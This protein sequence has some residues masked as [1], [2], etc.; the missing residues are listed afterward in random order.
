MDK[1]GVFVLKIVAA[2]SEIALKQL[3]TAI[4][5]FLKEEYVCAITLAGAAEEILGKLVQRK[6]KQSLYK[7][8][9]SGLIEKYELSIN[10]KELIDKYLNFA[11]NTLKHANATDEDEI[12][13][14]VQTEAISLIVR[15]I[16]N[17]YAL[18][19]SVSYNTPEF[20]NWIQRNR[21]ELLVKDS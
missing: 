21:T 6:G 10:E 9:A 16:T 5:L 3:E 1:L 14:E 18:D 13:L 15:A 7:V 19:G 20:L 12:E 11:R 8:L 2:K 4:D 17:L